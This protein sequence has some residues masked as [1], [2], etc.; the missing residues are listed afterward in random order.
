MKNILTKII[1][2]FLL[3]T[4]ALFYIGMR[5]Y[6]NSKAVVATNQKIL[7][8]YNVI[9]LNKD[10]ASQS[11]DMVLATRGF[12]L[13]EDSAYL[14]PYLTASEKYPLSMAKLE[15]YT[16]E[17]PAE[18]RQKVSKLHSLLETRKKYSE[19]YVV[20]RQEKGINSA[21]AL[22]Q[23]QSNG[24]KIMDSIRNVTNQIEALETNWLQ[25][26]L[27]SRET[28]YQELTRMIFL[29][30]GLIV[31]TLALVTWIL[32]RDITGRVK[33][34]NN[35][36]ILNQD[37][38]KQVETRTSELKRAFEDMEVKVRFRNLE[39]EQQNINLQKRIAELEK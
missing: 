25:E 13:T 6:N 10:L 19:Q 29:L 27:N 15:E 1:L 39:L 33:A 3:I 17:K 7:R 9:S 31:F 32:S 37:L 18:I 14:K 2:A 8:S 34:E 20:T 16:S 23:Q 38:E 35:L 30:A 21:I 36:K 11:K 26:K 22:F 24:N 4:A 28:Q 12:L 5:L